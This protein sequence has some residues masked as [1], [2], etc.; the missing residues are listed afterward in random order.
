MFTFVPRE[1]YCDELTIEI[2]TF[3]AVCVFNEGYR[4]IL[5]IMALMRIM[6][7]QNVKMFAD[8]WNDR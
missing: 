2:S 3:I 6:I 4:T 7:G 1:I 8:I 5:Q